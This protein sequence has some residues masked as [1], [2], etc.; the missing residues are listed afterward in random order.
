[1]QLTEDGASSTTGPSAVLNVGA[2]HSTET[3]PVLNLRLRTTGLSVWGVRRSG[4]VA[5]R[6]LVRVSAGR[7]GTRSL[8]L[9][10]AGRIGTRSLVRV[11]AGRIGTRSLVRVSAG[12]IGTWSLL[13]VSAGKCG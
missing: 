7:I 4:R 13:R 10:I 11:S 2:A 1:M 12:R 6:S 9:V 8:V 5:T 3:G